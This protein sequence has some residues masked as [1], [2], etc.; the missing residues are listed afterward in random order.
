MANSERLLANHC[1]LPSIGQTWVF[2]PTDAVFE[3]G[4]LIRTM[5]ILLVESNLEESST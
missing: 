2:A 3:M 1:A 5:K 4:V